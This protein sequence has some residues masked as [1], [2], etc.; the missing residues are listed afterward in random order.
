MPLS[1][2]GSSYEVNAELVTGDVVR[3]VRSQQPWAAE[4]HHLRCEI[5]RRREGEDSDRIDS[6]C[7]DEPISLCLPKLADHLANGFE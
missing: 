1:L 6:T 4:L 5:Q 2:A 3:A 7:Q